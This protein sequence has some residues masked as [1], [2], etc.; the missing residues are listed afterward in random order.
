MMGAFAMTRLL[1]R[2]AERG[3]DIAAGSPGG[4]RD[5]RIPLAQVAL[6]HLGDAAVR[7][8]RPDGDRRRLAV[9]QDPDQAAVTFGTRRRGSDLGRRPEAQGG[10]WKTE[11]IV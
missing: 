11:R 8:P 4:L 3:W 5:Q 9:A 10:V 6:R 2:P 7:K 1:E